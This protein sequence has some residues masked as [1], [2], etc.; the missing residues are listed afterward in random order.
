M[1]DE[2]TELDLD[3]TPAAYAAASAARWVGHVNEDAAMD[4]PSAMVK[5]IT[6]QWA[7]A[8][9]N[10]E[11]Q[12]QR[13][14]TKVLVN[15]AEHATLQA[16]LADA[17]AQGGGEVYLPPGDWPITA[18]LDVPSRVTIR[19]ARGARIVVPNGA[20]YPALD[21]DAVTDV[22][23]IGVTVASA[24]TPGSGG[25]AMR[26]R[27]ACSDIEVERCYAAGMAGGF[28][29]RGEEGS[30]PATARAI[31]FDRCRAHDT[32]ALW[33]FEASECADVIFRRCRADRNWLDGFK[34]RRD[35]RNVTLDHCS[36]SENGQ[37]PSSAGDGI[38]AFAGGDT[39]LILGGVFDGNLGNGITIKTDSLTRDDAAT[40]GYVRNIQVIG[41][42]CR[43]NNPG[44]GMGI[45]AYRAT[46]NAY[47]D[48]PPSNNATTMP[49]PC[50]ALVVGG[51]FEGNRETGLWLDAHN[52]VCSGSLV[53]ANGEH[54][55]EVGT[56][57]I[58]VTLRDCMVVANGTQA[59]TW[60]GVYLRGKHIRMLGGHVFGVDPDAVFVDATLTAA[61]PT[62]DR[63]ILVDSTYSEDVV[64]RDVIQAYS[65]QSQGIRTNMTTGHC[66]IHQRGTGSPANL[67]YGGMGSTWVQTDTTDGVGALWEKTSGAPNAPGTGWVRRVMGRQTAVTAADIALHANWGAGASVSVDAGSTEESGRMVITVGTTPGSQPTATITFPGGAYS[68]APRFQAWR[69]QGNASNA[70]ATGIVYTSDPTTTTAAVF[71]SGTP[72]AGTTLGI[73]WRITPRSG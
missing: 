42:R 26:I 45:Y 56:R 33:G 32:V 16:A 22:A 48:N 28:I 70:V 40:Y 46:R 58:N 6:A 29:V 5:Y 71:P 35:T 3:Q 57:A 18:R 34:V 14:I 9:D 49:M 2:T 25:Y 63:N 8:A 61:T 43:N 55:I 11:R 72:T 51:H 17:A 66:V 38:D 67:V 47:F 31:T 37:A 50:H 53:K 73:S 62:H 54:G 41:V 20:T 39:F 52:L 64:I 69:N 19:G 65:V 68:V 7:N 27:G 24:G 1:A 23:I 4:A 36:A 60:N 21:L 12:I 44:Y 30:T 10:A 13:K 59:G 15:A